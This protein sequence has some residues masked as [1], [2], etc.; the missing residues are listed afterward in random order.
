[1]SEV[2]IR[3]SVPMELP[4]DIIRSS[5]SGIKDFEDLGSNVDV[6]S[7]FL[8][9]EKHGDQESGGDVSPSAGPVK[10]SASILL[11]MAKFGAEDL[12]DGLEIPE[13]DDEDSDSDDEQDPEVIRNKYK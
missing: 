2:I 10:K 4:E 9:F 12:P 1:M 5:S 8:V 3:E 6:K 13:E 7:R 11:K